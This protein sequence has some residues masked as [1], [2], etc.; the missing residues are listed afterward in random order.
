LQSQ[1]LNLSGNY[2]PEAFRGGV[3]LLS[4]LG[5]YL[6]G[7][8]DAILTALVALVAIDFI[9][10][11]MAAFNEKILNSEICYKGITRKVAIFLMVAIGAVLDSS[12]G[13]DEP[14]LRTAII[15]FFIVNE[16]LSALENVGRLGL[17]IP[18]FL[19]AALEKLHR[20][21]TTK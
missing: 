20:E 18:E 1:I 21:N 17:P 10:G 14:Y 3:A 8:W 15:A 6:F 4:S 9:T 11:V 12:G 7:G 5:V 16:A 13:L 19:K 2:L